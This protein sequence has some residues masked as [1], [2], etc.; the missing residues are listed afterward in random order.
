[1]TTEEQ[2]LADLKSLRLAL[3]EIER[4]Q[5]QLSVIRELVGA[6]EEDSTIDAVS[7]LVAARAPARPDSAPV[8]PAMI[9]S[10]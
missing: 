2:H 3:A 4:L 10:S 6:D 9:L 8:L 5:L 7:D 1:M